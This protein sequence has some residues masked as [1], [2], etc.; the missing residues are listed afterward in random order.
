M[1]FNEGAYR[2]LAHRQLAELFDADRLPAGTLD[3]LV[4]QSELIALSNGDLLQGRGDVPRGLALVVEGCVALG[5]GLAGGGGCLVSLLGPGDLG[6]ISALIDHGP[7]A[8][9]L[10]SM[11]SSIVLMVP[12][13]VLMA[14]HDRHEPIRATLALQ[15]AHRNRILF[16]RTVD[17]MRLPLGD[18]LSRQLD[19]LATRFGVQRDKGVVISLRLSQEDLAHL[20]GASRQQ[21]NVELKRME[22]ASLIAVARESITILDLPALRTSGYA[23]MPMTLSR[24]GPVVLQQG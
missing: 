12:S 18:R 24:Q 11:G 19:F 23:S 8:A 20:L 21:V 2:I 5:V 7:A 22:R 16:D 13:A 3:S 17:L 9:D 1:T 4:Q 6:C 15:M 10:R 14:A